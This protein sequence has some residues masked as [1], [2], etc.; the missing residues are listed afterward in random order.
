VK[1]ITQAPTGI[2]RLNKEIRLIELLPAAPNP[3]DETTTIGV[4]VNQLPD[5]KQ[6]VIIISDA[7][8]KN[9]AYLPFTLQNGLNEILYEHGFGQNGLY[10]YSLQIGN[11]IY[12]T[13]KLIFNK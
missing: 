6:A 8:G 1:A 7:A 3:F 12:D 5:E 11:K 9:I 10:Y 4:M 13:R 2:Q